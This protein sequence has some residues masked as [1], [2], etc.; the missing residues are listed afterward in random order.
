MHGNVGTE[1]KQKNYWLSFFLDPLCGTTSAFQK[2]IYKSVLAILY[3]YIS[4]LVCTLQK[5]KDSQPELFLI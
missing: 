4:I 2:L 3:R 1:L 5:I